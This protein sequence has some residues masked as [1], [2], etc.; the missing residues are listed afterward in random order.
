MKVF[1]FQ[2]RDFVKTYHIQVDNLCQFL[3]QDKVVEFA[4]QSK[5]DLL[6]NTEKAVSILRSSS[7]RLGFNQIGLQFTYWVSEVR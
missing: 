5:G 2:V 4:R 1:S 7:L 6:L 3:A